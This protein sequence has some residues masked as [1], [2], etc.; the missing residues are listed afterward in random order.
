MKKLLLII[1]AMVLIF[2][3]AHAEKMPFKYVINILIMQKRSVDASLERYKSWPKCPRFRPEKA[4]SDQAHRQSLKADKKNAADKIDAAKKSKT[5]ADLE[6][7]KVA[8]YAYGTDMYQVVPPY[9]NRTVPL[10]LKRLP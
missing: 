6:A 8:V 3:Q 1:C 5:D 2:S 10:P 9:I 4:C 7:A